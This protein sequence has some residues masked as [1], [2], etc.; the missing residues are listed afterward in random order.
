MDKEK[1]EFIEKLQ[2]RDLVNTHAVAKKVNE[3]IDEI[4]LT[5]AKEK[6]EKEEKE[7]NGSLSS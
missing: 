6:T 7:E 5:I 1:G 4:N 2:G 3:I